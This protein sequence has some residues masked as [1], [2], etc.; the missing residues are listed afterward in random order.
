MIILLNVR[1]WKIRFCIFPL[2][3]L[4]LNILWRHWS[5]VGLI[6]LMSVLFK[7]WLLYNLVSTFLFFCRWI[8]LS[9]QNIFLPNRR[10]FALKTTRYL[11][12]CSKCHT[13]RLIAPTLLESTNRRVVLLTIWMAILKVSSVAFLRSWHGCGWWRVKIKYLWCIK[14]F[15]IQSILWYL[16]KRV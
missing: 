4:F 10:M 16:L 13:P 5:Q 6:N 1:V 9:Y 2:A 8:V 11:K 15:K 12:T 3:S 7:D 14:N